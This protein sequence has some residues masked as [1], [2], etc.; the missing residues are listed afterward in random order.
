MPK[1]ISIIDMRDWLTQYEQ[2]KSI[3]SIASGAHR[4]VKTV[5]RGIERARLERDA[6]T[7]RAGLIKDRLYRHQNR[8]LAIVDNIISALKVLK[9][10][11]WLLDRNKEGALIP[12]NL[13]GAKV[14]YNLERGLIITLDDEDMPEWELLI[15]HLSRTRL[16]GMLK[17]WKMDMKIHLGARSDMQLMAEEQLAETGYQLVD[18]PASSPFI[19]RSN[20]ISTICEA[21]LNKLIAIG[22]SPD[23]N[24][25]ITVD[26]S[27]GLVKYMSATILAEAPSKEEECKKLIIDVFNELYEKAK[28]Q[29]LLDTYRKVEESTFKAK[30]AAEEISLLGLV[31]G[32]CRVCRHLG[33]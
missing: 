32:Q 3:V 7:A 22:D 21:I 10:D 11:E 27:M 5:K 8:L 18:N 20:T 14:S 15:E 19:Y 26:Y 33:M 30:R 17:Q 13:S 9:H 24:T 29:P 16:R 25:L 4:D 12:I 28:K 6:A 31:P 1:K 2:G 23:F